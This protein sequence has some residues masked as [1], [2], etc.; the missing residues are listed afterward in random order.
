MVLDSLA[1]GSAVVVGLSGALAPS[2]GA[3]CAAVISGLLC[4][5][6]QQ[7]SRKDNVAKKLLH[8]RSISLR[9]G[10]RILYP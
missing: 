4:F 5:C 8:T 9:R 2:G 7:V 6:L 3:G 10:Q 1:G